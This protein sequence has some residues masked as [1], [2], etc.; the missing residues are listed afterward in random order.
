MVSKANVMKWILIDHLHSGICFEAS[1]SPLHFIYLFVFGSVCVLAK[2]FLPG[3]ALKSSFLICPR[4]HIGH[5]LSSPTQEVPPCHRDQNHH[6]LAIS[7]ARFIITITIIT[8]IIDNIQKGFWS[9]SNTSDVI[10]RLCKTL[11]AAFPLNNIR[12]SPFKV[13]CDPDLSSWQI[14]VI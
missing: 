5:L 13:P 7:I 11:K 14:H 8:I 6:I 4:P 9:L 1:T 12:F 2:D 10:D 3:W